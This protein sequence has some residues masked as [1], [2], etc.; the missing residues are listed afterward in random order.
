MRKAA[1]SLAIIALASPFIAAAPAQAQAPRTWV[2]GAGDDANPCSRTAPCR[3]FNAAISAAAAGGEVNCLDAGSFGSGSSTQVFISKSITIS[4]E[5][6]TA[7]IAT[8]AG[9]GTQAGIVINA[10]TTDVVTLRGLDIDGA[11]VG[12]IGIYIQSAK[13]VRVE[14]CTIR[15][16][17][18]GGMAQGGIL[19]FSIAPFTVFLFVADT[20]ISDNSNGL[21]LTNIG[22]FKVVSLKHVTITGSTAVGVSLF[23]SNVYV[24]VTKSIISGNGG[25]AIYAAGGATANIDRS[26]IA[27]N[28]VALDAAAGGATIRIS[29][30][31]IF[32][33][34]TGFMIAGGA[35]IQSDDSNNTGSSN[36]GATVP[37]G[38]LGKN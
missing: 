4:C 29:G 6:G 15:N 33:N 9:G 37:N 22:G 1:L 26:T 7:G 25:S 21:E 3:T 10:A 23:S 5:A 13:A 35:S 38:V 24:N 34:T 17:R 18:A 20:V 19:T 12:N 16:F 32:N 8:S 28:A 30:N 31:N 14:K 11:G 2:S 27:N 36:G